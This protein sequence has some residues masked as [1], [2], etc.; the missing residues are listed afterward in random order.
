MV[1][2]L[3][4]ALEHRVGALTQRLDDLR[5]EVDALS[6][7]VEAVSSRRTKKLPVREAGT[8][9]LHPDINSAVCPSANIYRFQQGCLGTA[10]VEKNRQYYA[11]RRAKKKEAGQQA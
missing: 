2:A 1:V 6:I 9:G 3:L 11:D 10:C 8:C 5:D 7:R 4:E